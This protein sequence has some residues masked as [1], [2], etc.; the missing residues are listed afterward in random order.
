MGSGEVPEK[1]E[2]SDCQLQESDEQREQRE[3]VAARDAAREDASSSSALNVV[4]D[5]AFLNNTLAMSVW[6]LC[7]VMGILWIKFSRNGY[8][9]KPNLIASWAFVIAVML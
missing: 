6:L 4:H 9:K 5:L 8:A 1:E 7:C 3:V 2:T